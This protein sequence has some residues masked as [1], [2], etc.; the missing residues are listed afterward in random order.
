MLRVNL[1]GLFDTMNPQRDAHSVDRDIIA[2]PVKSPPA[3]AAGFRCHLGVADETCFADER[4]SS[5]DACHI[6]W[7][8][9]DGRLARVE[10]ADCAATAGGAESYGGGARAGCSSEDD[11]GAGG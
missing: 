10:R 1:C 8:K 5:R 2:V 3:V 9:Q 7:R 11:T 4:M 6:V